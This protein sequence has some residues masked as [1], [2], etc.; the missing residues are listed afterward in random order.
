[1]KPKPIGTVIK[2]GGAFY[3]G[4]A[5][6]AGAGW[7]GDSTYEECMLSQMKGQNQMMY[8]TVDKLCTR[9][10]KK[11]T[12][13]PR[14][15]VKYEFYVEG[16]IARIEISESGEY[17]VTRMNVKFSGKSCDQAKDADWGEVRDIKV[18]D[19]LSKVVRE[20][21]EIPEGTGRSCMAVTGF[22]G[23]YK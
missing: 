5:A 4:L 2:V 16:P 6:T 13:V 19:N 10:F 1:M 23:I 17:I 3:L 14:S 15:E 12:Y 22:Y 11:E 7:F 18:T 8:S 20:G 9:K 21:K